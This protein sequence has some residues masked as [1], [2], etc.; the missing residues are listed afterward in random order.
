MSD[1]FVF[2]IDAGSGEE[3]VYD[4]PPRTTPRGTEMLFFFSA[5]AES[6]IN[7]RSAFPSASDIEVADAYH[8]AYVGDGRLVDVRR[9]Q[10]A[11]QRAN[12]IVASGALGMPAAVSRVTREASELEDRVEKM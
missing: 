6:G 1:N 12:A 10:R 9:R 3:V 2:D 4:A 11:Q 5:E 7:P 8:T